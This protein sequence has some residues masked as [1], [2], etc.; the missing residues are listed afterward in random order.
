MDAV[1]ERPVWSMSGGEM[2]STLDQL[3]AALAR[4]ET[5]RLQVIAGLDGV[6]HAQEI[7]AH[8]TVQLLEFRYRLDPARAR[9]D[10]RLALSLAKYEA[11]KAALP[12]TDQPITDTEVRMRPAQAEAIVSALEK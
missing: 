1:G 12:T 11:V 7:G 10:V 2:L 4:M 3:D 6:G 9:R 8:N 5:Y